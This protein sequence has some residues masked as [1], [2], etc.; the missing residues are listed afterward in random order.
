MTYILALPAAFGGLG[1][2]AV[3]LSSCAALLG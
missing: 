1:L 2:G 3:L